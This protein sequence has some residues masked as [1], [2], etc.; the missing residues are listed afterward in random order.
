MNERKSW[1]I[2]ATVGVAICAINYYMRQKFWRFRISVP[3]LFSQ[4][5]GELVRR[6]IRLAQDA[7]QCAHLDLTMHR[8][9]TTFGPT[10]HDHV[11]SG[12]TDFSETE[13][14]KSLT[15]DA[16][17][18]RGSLGINRKAEH[19]YYWMPR[20]RKRE[21]GQIEGGRLFQIGDGLFHRFTLRGGARLRVERD[22]PA[23]FGGCKNSGQFHVDTSLRKL[24]HCRAFRAWASN[25]KPG[26][27]G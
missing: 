13:T 4:R 25:A 3:C 15:I 6:N 9:Y 20:S 19:G 23:F 5:I 14:F 11:A 18:V 2:T 7:G 17:E 24:S 27:L 12:L 1:R 26:G 22:I 8:H 10:P 16:P 21:L